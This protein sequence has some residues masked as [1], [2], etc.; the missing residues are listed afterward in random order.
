M[1]Q[2]KLQ[3]AEGLRTTVQLRDHILIVDEP[4]TEGG[5]DQGPT[6][7]ELLLA[8][9]GACA[10]I[11]CKMYAGRK[12]WALEGVEIDLSMEKFK[13]VDYPTYSGAADFVNEF[14]Q[15]ITFKGDLTQEQRERLLQIAGK[16]PVHRILTAPNFLY[17]ELALV[18]EAQVGD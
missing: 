2:V 10:A 15:R 12:G 1:V 13:A 18:D 6:P 3:L 9:L 7:T 5:G 4:A 14:R 17:E 11:T 8:S 16:C